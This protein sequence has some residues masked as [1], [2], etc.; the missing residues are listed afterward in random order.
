[1][2][3]VADA[4]RASISESINAGD[5]LGR[6]PGIL[7]P[8]SGIPI[9]DT[10]PSTPTGQITWQDTVMLKYDV[11]IACHNEGSYLCNQ[12]TWALLM[13]MSDGIGRPLFT[14]S[15]IQGQPAFLLN[16]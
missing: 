1:M 16:G 2:Q 13:T 8:N 3:R 10:S 6:P 15:P 7:S 4:V 11:P 9:L 14:P 5:G 12:R